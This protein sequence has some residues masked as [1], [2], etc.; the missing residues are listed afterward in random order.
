MVLRRKKEGGRGGA[1]SFWLC[2]STKCQ[3]AFRDGGGQLDG[4][5][6]NVLRPDMRC[7]KCGLMLRHVFAEPASNGRGGYDFWACVDKRACGAR[8][9]NEDGRIGPEFVAIADRKSCPK[10]GRLL[11][12]IESA[13]GQPVLVCDTPAGCQS[14]FQSLGGEPGAK[15]E[16]SDAKPRC[17][18]CGE[19]LKFVEKGYRDRQDVWICS[20]ADCGAQYLHH[21]GLPGDLVAELDTSHR[22]GAC[23]SPMK[24]RFRERLSDHTRV[25]YFACL[26]LANCG[27]RYKNR[28]GVPGERIDNPDNERG[29][30]I[31]GAKLIPEERSD[32]GGIFWVCQESSCGARYIDDHDKPGDLLINKATDQKCPDCG[33]SLRRLVRKGVKPSN[34]EYDYWACQNLEACGHKFRDDGDSPGGLISIFTYEDFAC[35][36]CGGAVG[37]MMLGRHGVEWLCEN[38]HLCGARFQDEDGRPGQKISALSPED[39]CPDCGRRV[40]RVKGKGKRGKDAWMCLGHDCQGLFE[41]DMGRPGRRIGEVEK[42]A[43]GA[44]KPIGPPSTMGI[45]EGAMG[46]GSVPPSEAGG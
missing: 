3:A 37:K 44:A 4:R 39:V 23:G 40:K 9:K 19:P 29:C 17:R 46:S 14:V 28:A 18:S 33:A 36:D 38:S 7:P 41:N 34:R 25:D 31:C 42:T 27:A 13:T 20:G 26:D 11:R 35:P 1:D 10:C 43:A 6:K 24:R 8:F 16:A 30:R 22:C 21:R 45:A 12:R 5:L 32:K 2:P 15:L